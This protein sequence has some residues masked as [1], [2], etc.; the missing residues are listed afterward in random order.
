MKANR[1]N[2]LKEG[3]QVIDWFN[4]FRNV[5]NS[6]KPL[7]TDKALQYIDYINVVTKIPR[8]NDS[9]LYNVYIFIVRMQIW[10]CR[11]LNEEIFTI[12]NY[13]KL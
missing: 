5:T 9:I 11:F 7:Q 6:T 1:K 8:W 3:A 10:Q 4:S 2:V 13:M 12:Q